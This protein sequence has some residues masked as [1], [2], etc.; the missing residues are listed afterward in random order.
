MVCPPQ[1]QL[2]YFHED[3]N[4]ITPQ[5]MNLIAAFSSEFLQTLNSYRKSI[6]YETD[7]QLENINSMNEREKSI[8]CALYLLSMQIKKS[9]Q[10]LP[11]IKFNSSEHN[12]EFDYTLKHIFLLINTLFMTSKVHLDWDTTSNI[13]IE[14]PDD[15]IQHCRHDL[16][17]STLDGLEIGTGEIKPPNTS[18]ELVDVDRSKIAE[19]LKSS[20]IV[21]YIQLA[22]QKNFERMV[23]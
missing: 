5:R 20:C 21:D 10:V 6:T 15:S 18:S 9:N 19:S 22:T 3:I 16:I 12:R 23:L 13:Y 2:H 11:S 17:L 1:L 7:M 4:I 8:S 14:C